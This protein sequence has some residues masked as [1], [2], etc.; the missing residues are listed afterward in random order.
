MGIASG[1][2][3]NDDGSITSIPIQQDTSPTIDQGP[4]DDSGVW[5]S[6]WDH[7]D[8]MNLFKQAYNYFSGESQRFNPVTPEEDTLGSVPL[9]ERIAPTPKKPINEELLQSVDPSYLDTPQK[10]ATFRWAATQGQEAIDDNIRYWDRQ[11]NYDRVLAGSA[12]G[13]WA[14]VGAMMVA[15]SL[16]PTILMTGPKVLNA[17]NT[18]GRVGLASA[19]TARAAASVGLAAGKAVGTQELTNELLAPSQ[20]DF[21]EH[22]TNILIG[23]TFGAVVGGAGRYVSPIAKDGFNKV[24]THFLQKD[25]PIP[26]PIKWQTVDQLD[27]S[28]M[29]KAEMKA[30][31]TQATGM[32]D[33]VSFVLTGGARGPSK[34]VFSNSPEARLTINTLV[35]HNYTVKANEEGRTV[36]ET[37]VSVERDLIQEQVEINELQRW[38]EKQYTDYAVP[39]SYS[40]TA[41]TKASLVGLK[42]PTL[43]YQNTMN[44]V[45]VGLMDRNYKSPR[46]HVN[47]IRDE[48]AA[49]MDER[50]DELVKAKI[51]G[52]DDL[53]DNFYRMVFRDK[54]IAEDR[55]NFEAA[56]EQNARQ[57]ASQ[58]PEYEFYSSKEPKAGVK[59]ARDMTDQDF[60]DLVRRFTDRLLYSD[61]GTGGVSGLSVKIDDFAKVNAD[62]SYSRPRTDWIDQKTIAPWLNNNADQ[63]VNR[64][65]KDSGAEVRLV[66]AA[67]EMGFNNMKEVIADHWE[68]GSQRAA[69]LEPKKRDKAMRKL[70]KENE[71]L[72]HVVQQLKGKPGVSTNPILDRSLGYVRK[73]NLLAYLGGQTISALSDLAMPIIVHGPSREV[74]LGYAKLIGDRPAVKINKLNARAIGSGIDLGS[75]RILQALEMPNE[76]NAYTLD[77]SFLD[78]IVDSAARGFQTLT[79]NKQWTNF[80]KRLALD[81]GTSRTARVL[82]R[83]A[84]TGKMSKSDMTRLGQLGIGREVWQ[85]LA[86]EI[87][88]MPKG[89]FGQRVVELGSFKNQALAQ[90]FGKALAKEVDSVIIT[91]GIGDTPMWMAKSGVMKTIFQFSNFMTAFSQKVLTAQLQRKD[92]KLL[93]GFA[94]YLGLQGI[95]AQM[96]QAINGREVK[97]EPEQFLKDAMTNSGIFGLMGYKANQGYSNLYPENKRPSAFKTANEASLVAGPTGKTVYLGYSAAK[98]YLNGDRD[99][100]IK[101]AKQIMPY[102]NLFYFRILMN[103]VFG[104]QQ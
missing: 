68:K 27:V 20:K 1:D 38:I 74:F 82:E 65:L 63:V 98:D 7:R 3:F 47:K 21:T 84:D 90:R 31:D 17:I 24:V 54:A 2:N 70:K 8:N 44:E 16:D 88:A 18:A 86:D 78:K 91:P 46:E 92:A 73:W 85:E 66:Q 71:Q 69:S 15:G 55:S 45:A 19:E 29:S 11:N 81:I 37:G 14:G 33:I 100:A 93:I 25:T 103:K 13:G 52:A 77:K 5:W 89:R 94:A 97:F 50:G 32:N 72:L 39:N 12:L 101:K 104:K 79:L 59:K 40:W 42:D 48:Y 35:D 87:K 67:K 9:I 51:L 95:Q 83:W 75:N 96:K 99:S 23:A 6:A 56:L 4:T 28:T 60:K 30:E 62:P 53:N 34:L 80:G 58:D 43:S 57:R 41:N 49:R 61:G 102:H 36:L 22:G 76:M 64:Y 26:E 10:L